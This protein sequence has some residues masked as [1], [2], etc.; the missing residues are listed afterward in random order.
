M[1]FEHNFVRSHLAGCPFTQS[2]KR[3]TRYGSF[4]GPRV[5][6]VLFSVWYNRVRDRFQS[7]PQTSLRRRGFLSNAVRNACCTAFTVCVRQMQN[8]L[9]R[10]SHF[11]NFATSNCSRQQYDLDHLKLNFGSL[12]TGTCKGEVQSTLNFF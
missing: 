5:C 4:Y 1:N 3:L 2:I 8:S 6:V 11:E 7:K 12:T 10:A 9:L